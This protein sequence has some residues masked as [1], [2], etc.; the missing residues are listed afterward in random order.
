[1]SS[2]SKRAVN[3]PKIEEQ[4]KMRDMTRGELEEVTGIPRSTL[5]DTLNAMDANKYLKKV[6]N[7]R[8]RKRA[9]W[10]IS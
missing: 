7:G 1:M 10:S 2:N 3:I 9:F 4:L 6:V 5:W 8:G